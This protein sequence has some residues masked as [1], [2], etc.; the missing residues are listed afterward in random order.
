MKRRRKL[1]YAELRSQ[2][3]TMKMRWWSG[4]TFGIRPKIYSVH[5]WLLLPLPAMYFAFCRTLPIHTGKLKYNK[6]WDRSKE[7]CTSNS[8]VSVQMVALHMRKPIHGCT[9][10][11]Q[12]PPEKHHAISRVITPLT[13]AVGPRRYHGIPIRVWT[14]HWIRVCS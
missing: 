9:Y 5:H 11:A 13:P 7:S 2:V 12:K 3:D 10:Y 1:R 8:L 14:L 4:F 6:T